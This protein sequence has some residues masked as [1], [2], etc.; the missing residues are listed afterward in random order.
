MLA[1]QFDAWAAQISVL[2]GRLLAW[3]R[4]QQ[5]QPAAGD[6][7][8]R[9]VMPG[10]AAVLLVVIQLSGKSY[11]APLDRAQ[12]ETRRAGER[13]FLVRDRRRIGFG[14]AKSHLATLIWIN[15]YNR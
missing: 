7:P 8:C 12:T 6:H 1:G 9:A 10:G 11:Q 13:R 4:Q 14:S 2:Q 5:S 3:Q 15:A